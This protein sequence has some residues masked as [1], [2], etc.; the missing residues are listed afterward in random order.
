[1]FTCTADWNLLGD[2]KLNYKKGYLRVSLILC[3]K[4]SIS[5]GY[6]CK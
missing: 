5:W 6:T 4:K 3:L 1:M 2:C